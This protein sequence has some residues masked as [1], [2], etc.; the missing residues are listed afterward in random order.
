VAMTAVSRRAP[1]A[2]KD[3]FRRARRPRQAACDAPASGGRRYRQIAAAMSSQS[4]APSEAASEH[5]CVQG[6]PQ[7][8][9][10]KRA[11]PHAARSERQV[12]ARAAASRAR[13]RRKWPAEAARLSRPCAN[14]PSALAG[15][16]RVREALRAYRLGTC[17]CSRESG[18]IVE[19]SGEQAVERLVIARPGSR[20]SASNGI[21]VM[22]PAAREPRQMM[23]FSSH[24]MRVE[25]GVR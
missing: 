9:R 24:I 2:C 8:V 11:R 16:G 21:P 4:R 25:G 23:D 22:R 20:C 13:E 18:A 6:W 10:D 3:G 12:R 1:P 15:A 14:E 17:V 7:G 19:T 5:D